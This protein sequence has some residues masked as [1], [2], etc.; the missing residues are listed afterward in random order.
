MDDI[1]IPAMA[2][3]LYRLLS[4]C[5]RRS[6]IPIQPRLLHTRS[7]LFAAH[8]AEFKEAKEKV[9]SLKEDPGNDVKLKMYALFKQATVG[10]CNAPKPGMMDFVGK[11]KWE[12]WNG[13]G[14]MS[15]DDAQKEYIKLVDSLVAAEEKK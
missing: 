6:F 12:A 4:F 7:P 15:Q 8:D 11:A 1:K 10:A 14:K 2:A 5:I 3:Q 9:S 13:L